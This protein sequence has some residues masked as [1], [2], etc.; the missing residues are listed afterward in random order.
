MSLAVELNL[1]DPITDLRHEA[2]L[3]VLHTANYLSA[4]GSNLFRH[5]SLTEA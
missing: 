1:D 5:Y 3:N 2:I 4:T